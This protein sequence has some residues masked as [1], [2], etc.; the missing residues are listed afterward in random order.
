[1]PV[2]GSLKVSPLSKKDLSLV[3]GLIRAAEAS[4]LPVNSLE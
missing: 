2:T 4:L 1:M 3:D